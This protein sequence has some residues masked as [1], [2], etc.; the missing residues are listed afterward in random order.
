MT[1]EMNEQLPA[2]R[3]ERCGRSFLPP[4][5]TSRTDGK[6][7]CMECSSREAMA[8]LGIPQEEQDHILGIM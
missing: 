5:Y 2:I 7:L 4:V 3:C 8:S 6:T 1:D